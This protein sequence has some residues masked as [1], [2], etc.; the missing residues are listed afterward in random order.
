MTGVRAPTQRLLLERDGELAQ[1]MLAL[2]D[3]ASGNGRLVVMEAAAGLGKSSLLQAAL[4]RARERGYEAL[5]ACG[6]E[7]EREFSFGMVRQLF[8]PRIAS[9]GAEEREALFAGA[10]GLARPLWETDSAD[11]P[12]ADATFAT[13]HGLYWLLSNLAER[14]QLVLAVDDLHWGDIPSLRFLAFLLPRLE[15]MS[16]A[17]LL[18]ARPAEPGAQSAPGADMLLSHLAA[19]ATSITVS[20]RP[21]SREATAALIATRLG[22]EPEPEFTD[23]CHAATVGNPFFIEALLR[24]IVF[25]GIAPTIAQAP[26]IRAL[27]PRAVSRAV[28]MRLAKVPGGASLAKAVA[29]LGE[30]AALAH[31]AQLAEMP[32]AAAA[33]AADALVRAAILKRGAELEFLHPVVRQAVYTDLAPHERAGQHARAARMLAAHG[34]HA[35]RVAAQLLQAEPAGDDWVVEHLAQAAHEAMSRGAPETAAQYL[36]RALLERPVQT[37]GQ[38]LQRLGAAEAQLGHPDAVV[39]LEQAMQAAQDPRTRALAAHDLALLRG[40]GGDV[41]QAV[42]LFEE[43]IELVMEDDRELALEFESELAAVAMFEAA[44]ARH[45]GTRVRRLQSEVSGHTTAERAL[46]GQIAL[47]QAMACAPVDDVAALAQRA[48]VTPRWLVGRVPE[49]PQYFHALAVL[50]SCDRY[51]IAAEHVEQAL[52]AGRSAGS[53]MTVVVA[54]YHRSR[55]AYHRGALREAEADAEYSVQLG[56]GQPWGAA[57]AGSL[58]SLLEALVDR[59]ALAAAQHALTER[60]LEG[61]IPDGLTFNLLLYTRGAL[62]LAQGRPAEALDDLREYA[63]REHDWFGANPALS[64]Y[65]SRAA[66]ALKALGDCDQARALAEEDLRRARA[67]GAPR[68]I[69]IALCTCGVVQAE[70]GTDLLEEAVAVLEHSGAQSELARALVEHGTWLRRANRRSEAR[71]PLSRGHELACSCGADGLAEQ[72]AAELQAAGA[73]PRRQLSTGLDALTPSERRIAAMASEGLSNPQIAQSLFLSLKTVETHLGSAYRKLDV[74][75]RSELPRFFG[76]SPPV[77]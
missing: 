23:A 70:R 44:S 20:L 4:V 6:S 33:Q 13:L 60:A 76:T 3:A 49:A 22:E 8:E 71:K 19:T 16:V 35:E 5:T 75:S 66:R 2:D 41:P 72:A 32:E 64:S 25:Q 53:P 29:V 24:E 38:L 31:A 42:R 74:H 68:A 21:L 18:A 27:G 17:L 26:R 52:D 11:P 15:E 46:F 37:D 67:F 39:H 57:R 30:R 28:V 56:S 47:L 34:A 59:G 63:R 58:A 43:A 73:R 40:L 51:D 1:I 55:L 48:L 50:V 14:R 36:R 69:G 54:S 61:H 65:R 10:A 7:L 9:A 45:V 77:V 12:A 62:R